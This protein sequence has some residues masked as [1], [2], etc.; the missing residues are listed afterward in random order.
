MAVSG[1]PLMRG[2]DRAWLALLWGA[3]LAWHV[4]LMFRT[5]AGQDEDFYGVPGSSIV[6]GGLARIPYIP[7]RDPQSIYYQA[8]VA[9]YA[10]P[11]LSF[12]FQ[13]L[14]H[15]VLGDGLGQARLAS[16]VAGMIAVVLVWEL[17]FVWFGD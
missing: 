8:D 3:F 10:L 6:R 9:L 11:P 13:A 1:L 14:V 12:Y 15:L 5:C 17:G 7:S 4:P 16:A 2:R